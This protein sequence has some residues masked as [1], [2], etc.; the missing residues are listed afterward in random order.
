MDQPHR[1]H[2]EATTEMFQRDPAL[3]IA[4]INDVLADGDYMDLLSALQSVGLAFGREQQLPDP[5]P[6][7][8]TVR[9]MLREM[10][11]KLSALV[12]S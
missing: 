8:E 1:D 11:S 5:H 4:Y 12:H 10:A 9:A 7:L 6:S 2:D 3:A